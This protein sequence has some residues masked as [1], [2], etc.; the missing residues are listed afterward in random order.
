MNTATKEP[1]PNQ[2]G[3][4]NPVYGSP[5]TIPTICMSLYPSKASCPVKKPVEPVKATSSLRKLIPIISGL[6]TFA[7]V[8]SILIIFMDTSGKNLSKKNHEYAIDCAT[9]A[10]NLIQPSL[11]LFA[12]RNPFTKVPLKYDT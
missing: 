1:M 9:K 10:V 7:T 5:N 3:A 2:F 8:L 6:L 4:M 12:T 11:Y